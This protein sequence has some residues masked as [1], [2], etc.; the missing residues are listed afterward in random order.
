MK[1]TSVKNPIW[2]DSKNTTINC[3]ITVEALGNEE[4]PFS[5]SPADCMEH[6]R[7]L[8][9]E[10]VSGVH[11]EVAPYVEPEQPEGVAPNQTPTI[12]GAQTL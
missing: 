4:L 6:G 1:I 10:L 2:A 11:G 8:F 5:A 3:V 9:A 12:E 7:V